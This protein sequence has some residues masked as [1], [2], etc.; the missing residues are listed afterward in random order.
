MTPTLPSSSPEQ[1]AARCKL[2]FEAAAQAATSW[3]DPSGQWIAGNPH[4]GTRDRYWLAFALYATG[5]TAFADAVIRAAVTENSAE[6]RGIPNHFNIFST[7]IAI[8]LLVTHGDK[9]AADVRECLKIPALEAFSFKPGDRQPDF[10]FHG[11]NDN[12]PSKASMGMILAGEMFGNADAVEHGLYNLRQMRAQLV[13]RGIHS[14]YNSPTYSPGTILGL[15]KIAEY[16]RNDEA[17]DIAL[18]IEERLWVD[19]AARF[20][21]EIGIMSG[22]YSRAYTADT[23]GH[24]SGAA[25]MLWFALGDLAKPSP[26]VFFDPS[27]RLPH[28]HQGDIPFNISGACWEAV[29]YYHIPDLALRL[30]AGKQYPFRAV[31]TAEM[32]DAGPDFPAR[33]VRIET[34]IERDFSVGTSSTPFLSGEQTSGYFTTYKRKAKVESAADYG[35]LFSKFV[36]D[37]DKPGAFT[38]PAT[39][40]D[41]TPYS[42]FIEQDNLGAR[43]N[44]VTLQA[45]STV[46]FLSHPHLNLGGDPDCAGKGAKPISRLGEMV[47]FPCHFGGVDEIIVGGKPRASWSGTVDPGEWIACRRGRLMVAFRPVAHSVEFGKPRMTLETINQ[48]EVLRT[49]FYNGEARLFQRSELRTMM[50]GFVAEHASVDDYGSL[51]EFVADLEKAQ[52][53][54]FLFSTR[55]VRYRRPQ[56]SR[57][58]TLELEVSWSPGS[59][60]PRFTIV[61]GRPVAWPMIEIDGVDSDRLPFV[62]ED[63]Q[64]I[65]GY[66]PWKKLEVANFDAISSI[67][68]RET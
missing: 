6:Y 63:W 8:A 55:R 45:G 27:C 12:M 58:E 53:T 56:G 38:D 32:G 52:F 65:P 68:D 28:H 26:M 33:P 7:N 13:R 43:S 40:A 18:G 48:Y 31:A 25:C 4:P 39:R 19:L 49:E 3:Y 14:E 54:D 11:Y 20:H 5:K 15:A 2:F 60:E 51:Q 64:S 44:F 42:K 9:M 57:C 46:M 59:H 10:Q 17:R 23:L 66:F 34:H 22:P 21:P 47:I 30:F 29:T 62:D 36:V 41:G 37:E 24:A 35:T 1:R 67:G 61:N 16:S 50:G